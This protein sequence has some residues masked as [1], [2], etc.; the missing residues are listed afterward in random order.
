MNPRLAA[1]SADVGAPL[2]A[3]LQLR[4]EQID[5]DLGAR[6]AIPDDA[7]ACGALDLLGGR[8][9][10]VRPDA[11]FYGADVPAIVIL[12]GCFDAHPDAA[13]GLD[14]RVQRE[15]ERMIQSSDAELAAR[16]GRA[17]GID[18]LVQIVRS[19]RYSLYDERSGGG[20][21][22][23]QYYGVEKP[24]RGD[25]L[26]DLSY[27]ATVRQCLRYFLMLERGELV[28][29]AASAKMRE[30]LAAP[31][32]DVRA[33]GFVAGLIGRDVTVVRKSGEWADGRLD[34]ARVEGRGRAYVVAAMA[35]HA[36]ADEYLASFAAEV[37]RAM[38]PD[39]PP[40]R[41]RHRTL[42]WRRGDGAWPI[43]GYP[44]SPVA[45]DA[46]QF[47]DESE[48]IR[49][50]M[51]FNEVLP[52]WNIACRDEDGVMVRLRVG[53]TAT[54]EWSPWL[55][56]DA[57]GDHPA[58]GASVTECPQGRID[59]DHFRSTRRFDAAQLQVL[60][61]QPRERGESD[62]IAIERL[63]VCFSDTTRIPLSTPGPA[64][65]RPA[66]LLYSS[67]Q[68]S[69]QRLPVPVRSQKAESAEL[70][71]RI[72]SPTSV[73]MV[74]AYRGV[75]RPTLDVAR[76]AYDPVH[77]IYGNWPRNVQAAFDLGVPG[78]VT[79]F[80]RWADVE[81]QIVAGQPLIISIRAQAGE[82]RGAPYASTDGH[83]LVVT[84]FA[85]NGDVLVNDPAA[86][87][88]SGARAYAREDLETA[89]FERGR[90][91]AYVLLPR[92]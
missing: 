27:G 68:L 38:Q 28:S 88:E 7:R 53:V 71:S 9:A 32:L 30:I 36:R 78:Y 61:R 23:G 51:W 49:P 48:V 77:D 3:A 67:R 55:T 83:L 35:R 81:R 63:A 18:R 45:D 42:V 29:P 52:S 6:L 5:R 16:Y 1:L 22:C 90:G 76:R 10:L 92:E 85:D 86:P 17:V 65:R 66:D 11:M 80:A 39:E 43:R 33:T 50:G 75:A 2:D 91:T 56:V 57:W 4:I 89:W 41:L 24:R 44:P 69:R 58:R 64:D 73:A 72:C 62:R 84:G 46:A 34:V 31:A 60:S 40:P 47:V 14:P 19:P 59:V 15:L 82:L 25:P 79:R 13:V 20:L 87:V 37:D 21:W 12:L 26:H 74:L 70:A 8:L 54:D